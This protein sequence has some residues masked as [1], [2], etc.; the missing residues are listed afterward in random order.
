MLKRLAAL[1]FVLV[2][3]G[4]GGAFIWSQKAI[5]ESGPSTQPTRVIVERGSGVQQIA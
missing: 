5:E 4:I 1:A 2:L 3:V